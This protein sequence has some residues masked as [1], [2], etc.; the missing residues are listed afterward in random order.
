MN[1]KPITSSRRGVQAALT[2]AVALALAACGGSGSPTSSSSAD[3]A[4]I[5]PAS[6]LGYIQADINPSGSRAQGIDAASL[7]LLGIADPGAKIVA[8]LNKAMTRGDSYEKDIQPWLGSTAGLAVISTATAGASPGTPDLAV[9]ADDKDPSQASVLLHSKGL[10]DGK[11]TSGSYN[12]VDYVQRGGD[13]VAGL[14]GSFFV[15]GE[16][17]SAFKAIVD[18]Y[19]G[20]AALSGLSSYQKAVSAELPGA[21]GVAYL[22]LDKLISL[23]PKS[24]LGATGASGVISG[25]VTKYAKAIISGSA[26]FDANGAAVDISESGVTPSGPSGEANPIG[27]L[28]AGSWLAAGATNV[29]PALANGLT[30]LVKLGNG[31]SLGNLTQSLGELQLA[32]GVNVEGDL[33]S[34]TTLGFF[35]KGTS[36]GTLEAAL[37]LAVKNPSQAPVLVGQYK[38]LAQLIASSDNSFTV[39]TLRQ[40]NIQA[41]FT[42]HVPNVPFTFDVAAGNGVIVIALGTTSLNDALASAD[43]LSST[44]LYTTATSRLGSGIQPDL[45][46]DLPTVAAL[47]RTLP[48]TGASSASMATVLKRLGTVAI[49][50]GQSGGAEHVRIIVSGG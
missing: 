4:S 10:F 45:I 13:G 25:L 1:R 21:D 32:T 5:V 34:I 20:G 33:K 19:K 12:G 47:V 30:E 18:V 14:V 43:R 26:R 46:L 17:L 35:V 9:I 6:A 22:P 38:R 15:V 8:L 42:I 27:N 2:C 7:R 41:G 23:I 24:T 48:S 29:G 16:N 40:S 50:S 49:G 36:L 11:G 28:P 3:P 31:G 39:G 44:A 37:E